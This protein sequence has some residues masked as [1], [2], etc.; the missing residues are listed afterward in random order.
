M[1]AYEGF[2][3]ENGVLLRYKG[4]ESQVVV[5]SHV[6]EIADGAFL[7]CK[8]MESV[9]VPA[10]L[11]KIGKNAFWGC[12]A[13]TSV[14]VKIAASENEAGIEEVREL[15]EESV[16]IKIAA[17]IMKRLTGFVAERPFGF[18]GLI[19]DAHLLNSVRQKFPETFALVLEY[20]KTTPEIFI[21]VEQFLEQKIRERSDMSYTEDAGIEIFSEIL[22]ILKSS[23]AKVIVAS[24]EKDNPSVAEKIKN[25][26]FVFSDIVLLDDRAIQKV[27]RL[28]DMNCLTKALKGVTEDVAEKIFRNMSKNASNMLKEDIMYMG[29]VKVQDVE[30]AQ[31]EIVSVVRQLEDSSDIVIC[32]RDEKFIS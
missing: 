9:T 23:D 12:T 30:E 27:L 16:R 17:D 10:T 20:I 21:V 13:L 5:P 32:H 1:S 31:D 2:E 7:N 26:L 29:P 22:R 14:T 11:T 4:Q 25:K 6:T 15:L 18:I 8:S 24:L 3:I 28:V 19:D